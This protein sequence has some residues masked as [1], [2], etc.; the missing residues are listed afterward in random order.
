MIIR[1]LPF[2]SSIFKSLDKSMNFLYNKL[3][4]VSNREETTGMN[5]RKKHGVQD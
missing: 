5:G 4:F 3:S 2:M 1:K